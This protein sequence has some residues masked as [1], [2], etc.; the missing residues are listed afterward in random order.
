MVYF[1]EEFGAISEAN[2]YL[3]DIKIKGN[4][5]CHNCGYFINLKSPRRGE[6]KGF[7]CKNSNV[8]F[9][10]NCYTHNTSNT[11]N[12]SNKSNTSNTFN[13]SNTS[14][15]FNTSNTS[16][17]FNTFNTFN[18]SKFLKK[19]SAPVLNYTPKYLRLTAAA[20]GIPRHL[21]PHLPERK[22]SVDVGLTNLSA[23][24]RG[25]L[26]RKKIRYLYPIT[27]IQAV[28][29]GGLSRIRRNLYNSMRELHLNSICAGCNFATGPKCLECSSKHKLLFEFYKDYIE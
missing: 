10:E 23:C 2:A 29:R 28:V 4:K 12:T 19:C 14:N 9:C 13:T 11:S 6:V 22:L 17:T 5:Q 20:L 21:F 25:Y 8:C 24:V 1:L 7:K 15:T 16:N 27:R 26:L 3:Y 18:T